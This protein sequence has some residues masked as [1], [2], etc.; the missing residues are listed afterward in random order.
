MAPWFRPTSFEVH[1]TKEAETN[2]PQRSNFF[3]Y[4]LIRADAQASAMGNAGK[5]GGI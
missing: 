2:I 4:H 5:R 1:A 3:L